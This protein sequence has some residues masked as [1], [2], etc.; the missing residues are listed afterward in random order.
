VV[1]VNNGFADLKCHEMPFVR[2]SILP[3]FG[4]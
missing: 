1:G 2:G 4:R 3:A